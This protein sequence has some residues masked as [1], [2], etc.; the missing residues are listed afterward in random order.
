M[1]TQNY[2]GNWAGKSRLFLPGQPDSECQSTAQVSSAVAGT[3]LKIDYTWSYEGKENEGLLLV[4]LPGEQKATASWTDSWHSRHT[5]MHCEG[6]VSDERI[7]LRGSY[8][9]E[10]HPDWGWRIELSKGDG[11]LIEMYNVM[12]DGQEMLGW[13]A[14]L[15]KEA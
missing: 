5:F 9:V 15:K 12:P 8:K 6:E 3:C 1:N 11:F 14:S 13:D 7:V 4:S 2:H 10:G